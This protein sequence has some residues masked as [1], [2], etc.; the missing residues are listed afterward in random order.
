MTATVAMGIAVDD[1]VH[2]VTWFRRGYAQGQSQ[3]QAVRFAYRL[4]GTAMVQTSL[5]VGLGLLVYAL[6][7]F[8]PIQRFAWLMFTILMLAL[9]SDLTVTPALLYSRLGRLFLPGPFGQQQTGTVPTVEPAQEPRE[10]DRR[11]S[12]A[13]PTA[14]CAE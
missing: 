5:I 2:Y 1:T 14:T 3:G 4:C 7:D 8:G 11:D 12:R 13:I 10:S 6:S 9:V